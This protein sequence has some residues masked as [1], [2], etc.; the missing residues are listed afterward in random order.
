VEDGR[1]FLNS[2]SKRY[3]LITSEPPPP[4]IAGVVNLYSEEYFTLIRERLN[5][6]GYASYWLPA[7]QLKPINTLAIIKAFCNAFE[8][9]SLW[10]GAGL[11]WMLLGSND[12][13]RHSDMQQFSAQWRD[14]QVGQELVA[15]GLESPAQL[16]SLFMADST[17]L[18]ELTANVAPVTDN[19]PSR[20]SSLSVGDNRYTELYDTLMEEGGRLERFGNS[21]QISNLWPA[22]LKKD[23]E[24]FFQYERLIKNYFTAGMYHHQTDPYFWEAIDNVLTETSLKTLPLW[25]LGSDRDSQRIVASLLELE[26][27]R[28]EFALELA[29][30]YASERDYE[31]AL[32]YLSN[33]IATVDDVSDWTSRFHLYL[34]AKNGMAAQAKPVIAN[35]KTI[36][37]P[38]I[39]KFLDWIATKF[40]LSSAES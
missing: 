15:L 14:P 37:R 6:G 9:C 20:I 26:G 31:T 35:L 38:G 28:D 39:E 11:E 3:D 22:E 12:A 4:M 23:S 2:T 25:L 1:F 10:S 32:R 21:E 33:H 8:D 17:R 13:S 18:K 24:V 5:P 36:G 34:L 19:F 27:Y 40:D 29:R 30:K 16:G 7:V